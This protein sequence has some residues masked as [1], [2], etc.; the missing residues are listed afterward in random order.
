[1][2]S[3]KE[4]MTGEVFTTTG[5]MPV[6]E[7]AKAMLKGRVGSAVVTDGAWLVGM[8]TERDVLRAAASGADLTSSPVSDWMTA[9][10]VTA[11][12]E[13]SSDEAAEIMMSQGFRHLP[14]VEG[15][16]LKGIVSLRDILRVRIR[17]PRQ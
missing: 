13:T 12:P 15:T 9:D 14:V 11:T 17:R 6:A 2:P 4:I 5:D 3:L 16:T 10:P 7:V 1:M 8:F